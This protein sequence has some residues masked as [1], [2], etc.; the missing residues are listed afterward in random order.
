[1][2]GID[3]QISH[4]YVL[5]CPE[6]SINP[7]TWLFYKRV[8]EKEELNEFSMPSTM[9]WLDTSPRPMGVPMREKTGY[10]CNESFIGEYDDIVSVGCP[11]C[12]EVF[13]KESDFFKEIKTLMNMYRF[14]NKWD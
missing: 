1:M 7:V 11:W 5:V 3:E 4:P 6:C 10:R 2:S 14:S 8:I 12:R 13:L 9:I